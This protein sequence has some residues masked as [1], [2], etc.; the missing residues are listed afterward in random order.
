MRPNCF[1]FCMNSSKDY[2]KGLWRIC[3]GVIEQAVEAAMDVLLAYLPLRSPMGAE[4]GAALS[5]AL[6]E[7][8]LC[9]GRGQVED[10]ADEAAKVLLRCD[11]GEPA[12]RGAWLTLAARAGGLENEFFPPADNGGVGGNRGR[13][14]AAIAA[15][16]P[17]AV[18]GCVR[19]M[20][21]TIDGAAAAASGGK[22]VAGNASVVAGGGESREA[23]R[24]SDCLILLSW[25]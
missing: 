7:R 2:V 17:K 18:A 24:L 8:A 20:K 6:A 13:S 22:A 12:G 16:A 14:K 15:S 3:C 1:L 9:C 25:S 21:A 19:A 11:L 23:V 5:S 10:K 4:E